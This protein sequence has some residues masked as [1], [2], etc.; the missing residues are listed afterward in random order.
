MDIKDEM[1]GTLFVRILTRKNMSEQKWLK[2]I[3]NGEIGSK[4]GQI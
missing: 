3:K 2:M 4:N 1:H